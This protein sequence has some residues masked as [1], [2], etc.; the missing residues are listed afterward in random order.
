MATIGQSERTTQERVIALFRD[1]LG[2]RSLGSA[3]TGPI[4][5]VKAH[6][7]TPS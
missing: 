7:A 6:I 1:E 2:Y 4:T 3:R 5:V